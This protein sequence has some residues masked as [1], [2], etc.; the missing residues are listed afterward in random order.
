MQALRRLDKGRELCEK[1]RKKD[2]LNIPAIL[3]MEIRLPS[4]PLKFL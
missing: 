3:H 4:I 1:E 2:I